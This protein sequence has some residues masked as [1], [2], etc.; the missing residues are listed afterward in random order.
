MTVALTSDRKALTFRTARRKAIAFAAATLENDS[1][2]VIWDG[3]ETDQ[4]FEDEKYQ[5]MLDK[6][7]RSAVAS[8]RRLLK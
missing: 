3:D 6:A 4:M 7:Q 8:I 2:D 5:D 1:F